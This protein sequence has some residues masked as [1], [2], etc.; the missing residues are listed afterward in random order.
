[1]VGKNEQVVLMAESTDP[2]LNL[3]TSCQ[4]KWEV[5][6]VNRDNMTIFP[7]GAKPPKLFAVN[8]PN[9]IEASI[10]DYFFGP[11]MHVKV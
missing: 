4:V 10:D 9:P 11:N 5:F 6:F 1:M 8:Y 3:S 7:T 2:H